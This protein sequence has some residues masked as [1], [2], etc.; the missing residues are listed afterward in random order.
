MASQ[1][2]L[3]LFFEEH[4]TQARRH[5]ELR[6]KATTVVLTLTGALI[7]LITY[8]KLAIWSWP[9]AALVTVLGL[10]GLLF[11][12]KHY[13]RARMH[14]EIVRHIREEIDNGENSVLSLSDLTR[15]GRNDHY[16]KFRWPVLSADDDAQSNAKSRIA[17]LRLN[18]FWD[19]IH[20]VVL[21]IGIGL[22]TAILSKSNESKEPDLIS[23][24]IVSPSIPQSLSKSGAP[25]SAET[26]P[27]A[28]EGPRK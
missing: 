16:D 23:V 9:A 5:E 6:E 3:H 17:R 8:S 21:M 22:T 13:E 19:G 15:N 2:N 28:V 18:I 27:K 1:I 20:V 7:G 11:S 4:A 14:T 12:A 24:Q 10:Y 26:L 25:P